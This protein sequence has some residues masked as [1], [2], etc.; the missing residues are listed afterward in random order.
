MTSQTFN[1]PSSL[2]SASGASYGF[3]GVG[4]DLRLRNGNGV[5]Y[6]INFSLNESSL[7]IAFG[8]SIR[9][10]DIG[11]RGFSDLFWSEG[12]IILTQESREVI[13]RASNGALVG[14]S[15]RINT[16]EI[17]N[18]ASNFQSDKAVNLEIRDTSPPREYAPMVG[19]AADI[20]EIGLSKTPFRIWS[21]EGKLTIQGQTY[22]GTTFN[23]GSFASVSPVE[24]TAGSPRSRVSIS[25]VVPSD[26]IRTM[27]NIDI[28]PVWIRVFNVVS[29]NGGATWTKLPTG[30]AG[31]LSAPVFDL[32]GSVWTAEIE[33]WS[34]DADRGS[35]VLW[36][37]A[38]QQKRQPGDIGMQYMSGYE[39]GVDIKW[40]P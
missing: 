17:S 32:E 24:N 16:P 28:G 4:V 10:G 14:S 13:L 38:A 34:G 1:F 15:F 2:V 33:T 27:L 29:Q 11:N 37:D 9:G 18:F 35:I 7:T 21:G 3:N 5:F 30:I 39:A 20:S 26:A 12:Y 8:Q 40:P 22:E 19:W 36:S 23:G 31:R 6:L 25:V